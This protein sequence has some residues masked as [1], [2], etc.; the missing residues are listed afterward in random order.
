MTTEGYYIFSAS[1]SEAQIGYGV[2]D[3]AVIY[4]GYL[5][6]NRET[7]LYEYEKF[8]GKVDDD[9]CFNLT[10]AVN[11]LDLQAI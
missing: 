5:N 3:E 1:N 8:A 11:E 7:S 9:N 6:T 2:E 10:D 4:C